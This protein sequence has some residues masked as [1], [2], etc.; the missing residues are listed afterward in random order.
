MCIRDRPPGGTIVLAAV[1]QL[2]ALMAV[3]RRRGRGR[4]GAAA[5]AGLARPG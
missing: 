5:G 1:L 4:T 3:G 2:L